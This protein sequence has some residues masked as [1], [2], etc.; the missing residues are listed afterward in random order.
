MRSHSS[1]RFQAVLCAAAV[2]S[3]VLI[4]RPFT[5]AGV[6]DDGVFIR[7]AQTFAK[8]G[9]IFYN[10]WEAP[11]MISQLYL[12]AIF[13]KL[14]G[15]SFTTVRMGTLLLA[16]L[17][18]FFFHRT[19]VRTGATA[20]NATL[21][22]L[23]AVTSPLFLMLSPTF[24]T[25]IYGLF[26][27][28]LCL[29]GCIRALQANADRS[30]V[31]WIWFA[32]ITCAFF[33]TS[34]QVAWLGNLVMVPGT[35]WLLRSRKRVLVAGSVATVLSILF[36]LGC[37]H[38]LSRQPYVIP[39]SLTGAQYFPKRV[40]ALQLSYFLLE[41][42]FV[43]LPIVV[44]FAP[45]I[46]RSRPFLRYGL[47]V[48]IIAYVALA[49]HYRMSPDPLI[50]FEPTAGYKGGWFNFAG[51]YTSLPDSPTLL[52][53]RSQIVLTIVCL[54]GFVGAI[55]VAVDRTQQKS[56]QPG[57]GELSW[58]QLGVLLLPFSIAYLLSLLTALMGKAT[59]NLFD[60]YTLGLYGPVF[61]VLIKLYQERVRR[62]LPLVTVLLIPVMAALGVIATHNTFAIDRARVALAN[63]LHAG[64]VPDTAIDGGW[65]Y[66]FVTELDHADHLN[67]PLIKV[68]AGAYVQP[69]PA[70][71]GYCVPTWWYEAPHVHP[72]YSMSFL[73]NRC[74]GKAPFAPVPYHPWPFGPTVE[75]YAVRDAP[76]GVDGTQPAATTGQ[77]APLSDGA[78]R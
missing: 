23:A 22:T 18:A 65:D 38:W 20:R 32:V 15:F 12:A 25:D 4:S 70:P 52:R 72:V 64:G 11:M 51:A 54:A 55:L 71:K 37:T 36:I 46:L 78:S 6:C 40:A 5:T 49:I 35:L 69:P 58:K 57:D 62:D 1:S 31:A 59:N 24:M 48:G 39:S 28:T 9:H 73:P 13:I 47:L 44:A 74:Y 34:R 21:G 53:F 3:C 7:V 68:P 30:A 42:P 10:G 41:L 66:S 77:T 26:A 2:A 43:A 67:V 60:R 27:I 61:I 8:T 63:E 17:T 76:V 45:R 56:S 16:V 33:G 14:F 29:Y 75:L 50:R 19:L